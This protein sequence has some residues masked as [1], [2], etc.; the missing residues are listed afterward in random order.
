MSINL[1]VTLRRGETTDSLVK[2]FMRES[3]NYGHDGDERLDRFLR[4]K[5]AYS[6]EY[7]KPSIAKRRKRKK[8]KA[9]RKT[10]QRLQTKMRGE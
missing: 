6:R 4:E 5:S 2:R 8:A 10:Q 1:E 9:R 7:V 3:R